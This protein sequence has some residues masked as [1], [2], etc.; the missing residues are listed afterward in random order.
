MCAE[1]GNPCRQS[2]SGPSSGPSVRHANSSPLAVT[3]RCSVGIGA[4]RTAPERGNVAWVNVTFYGVRGSCPC[5]GDRYR[6]YGGN[7]SCLVVDIEGD[8][9][10]IVDLGTGLRALGDVL[11]REVRALGTPLHATALL[12]HLHFDHI[13]GIPFFGPLHDPGARLTVYGPAQPKGSLKDA[14]HAAVQPPVFPIHMEQFRGEL[15]TIDVGSEDFSIGSAKIMARPMPHAGV[16][17]GFRIEA[18]GRSIAYMS[19]HQAPL[20]RRA[21]P[22]A[23]LELCQG[24]DL[25]IHDGQYTDDE[26]SAKADWGHSTAAYA[27]H[28][29]AEAGAKRLLLLA[30]RPV[31]HRPRAR[32]HSEPGPPAPRGQGRR[33]RVVGARGAVDRPRQG[34]SG[35]SPLC[36]ASTRPGS[37]RC[38]A[39]SPPGSPSS[40]R[41]RTACPSA[42]RCQSFAA[43][44][45]DPPMVILAPARSSTS[46]PRIAQAGAFCVNILGEHQEALCR[47]FA[48]SGGDKF[49][50]VGWTHGITGS[51][52]ITTRWRSWSAA[53][54]TSST[55]ATT[56]SSPVTWSPWTS[57]RARQPV[58]LLPVVASG[59]STPTRVTHYR[60]R[61]G[62]ADPF[63]GHKG[64]APGPSRCARRRAGPVRRDI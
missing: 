27:V 35:G 29:A 5:S 57:A 42:S 58:A 44:S 37:A 38:S 61:H 6:R 11:H 34:V 45:L 55:G 12:T 64:R 1:S 15:I 16:T 3:V 21:I 20:D 56:S 49:E 24:V 4:E 26:F 23:V 47:A 7:T 33:G 19:D 43:L 18:E 14:L 28:V 10:L 22:E 31:A 54:A 13:L 59:V 39:T 30:P 63:R 53:W 9:P 41:W 2:A 52:I 51:P 36:R 62:R 46:W 8:E 17:L 50:G 60:S 32:P 25:L 48:I 40:P